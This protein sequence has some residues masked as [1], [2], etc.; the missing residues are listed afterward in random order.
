MSG[1]PNRGTVAQQIEAV[2]RLGT[3]AAAIAAEAKA[4]AGL[5]NTRIEY[6]LAR[7]ERVLDD[8]VSAGRG[9]EVRPADLGRHL[10]VV[11]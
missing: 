5:A 2:E 7:L 10:K 1:R 9:P 3:E 6:L 11:R 8:E 4:A